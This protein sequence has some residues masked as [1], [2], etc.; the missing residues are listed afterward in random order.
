[1]GLLVLACSRAREDT[2]RAAA[3]T[4]SSPT[5][6]L[7]TRF[8]DEGQVC[9]AIDTKV[10]PAA[11]TDS[12][13]A[14]F[15]IAGA[16]LIATVHAPQEMPT[17]ACLQAGSSCQVRLEGTTLQIHSQLRFDLEGKLDCIATSSAAVVC[18]GPALTDGPYVLQHG[19][20]RITFQVPIAT[21]LPFCNPT[22]S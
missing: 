6:V 22:Q 5:P 10:A 15:L 21:A 1:M 13:G 16:P 3:T 18:D 12:Q 7:K 19:S 4:A 2:P 14:T 9:L 11:A 8:A 20:T 17:S